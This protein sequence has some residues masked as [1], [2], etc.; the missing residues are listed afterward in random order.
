MEKEA[1]LKQETAAP[2][3]RNLARTYVGESFTADSLRPLRGEIR[4]SLRLIRR[5]YGQAVRRGKGAFD[6]WLGDNYHLLNQE[7]ETLL[8]DLLFA[9]RQPSID[10]R[11]A[12][13]RLF[14]DLVEQ[15]GAPG[16]EEVDQMVSAA[17][18]VR[19]L[20]VFELSQLSLCLKAA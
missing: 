17:E 20:T 18:N 2:L 4:R 13:F 10:R 1:D 19:P 6:E 16:E 3:Y 5:V 9:A 14:L 11:P 15:Q 12:M 8:R 7:G